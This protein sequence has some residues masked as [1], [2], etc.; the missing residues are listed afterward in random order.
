MIIVTIFIKYIIFVSIFSVCV[1]V[2]R[3]AF[4]YYIYTH[5]KKTA[6]KYNIFER[7]SFQQKHLLYILLNGICNTNRWQLLWKKKRRKKNNILNSL[8]KIWTSQI[9]IDHS[10]EKLYN[11]SSFTL[12]QL[13]FRMYT[14]LTTKVLYSPLQYMDPTALAFQLRFL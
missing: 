9:V 12:H 11:S 7:F 3:H 6:G 8:K 14:S 2:F 5:K 4:I 13:R 1:C 10:S